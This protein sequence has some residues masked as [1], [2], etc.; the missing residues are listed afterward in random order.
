MGDELS[1][2]EVK[3]LIEAQKSEEAKQA[4]KDRAHVLDQLQA[5]IKDPKNK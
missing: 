2:D 4:E 1:D 3:A 5:K